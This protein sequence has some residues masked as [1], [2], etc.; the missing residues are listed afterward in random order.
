MKCLIVD[1]EV[2]AR[3][4]LTEY[5]NKIPGLELV[6]QYD[7][8][9][10]I[11]PHFLKREVDILL[12]DINM[13]GIT[14]IDFLKSLREKPLT[15]LTTAHSDYA[16]QGY[17]LDVID[18]LLKP[19]SF[20]RFYQSI[21]K[22]IDYHKR[23]NNVFSQESVSYENGYFYVKADYKII[24]VDFNDILFIEGLREYVQIYTEKQKII[25]H[26]TMQKL[27]EF[28]SNQFFFRIHKSHIVNIKKIKEI[29]GNLLTIGTHKLAI[30]KSQR[31]EFFNTID[32]LLIN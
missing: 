19:I 10:Q 20:E 23:K 4:L 31:K 18:Y 11:Q 15:I 30:S 25:T 5:I 8:P 12:L 26:I 6:A 3:K 9:L 13:P 27:S 24:R 17:E 16:L 14:G 2:L 29:E 22:A 7:S 28:L 1:D 32:H 21:D